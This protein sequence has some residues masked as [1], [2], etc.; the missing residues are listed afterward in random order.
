MKQMVIATNEMTYPEKVF[1]INN[2]NHTI[3][4][5]SP[6]QIIYEKALRKFRVVREYVGN[7]STRAR[8]EFQNVE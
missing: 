4:E 8:K 6:S 2:I 5:L 3:T 1:S 7:E